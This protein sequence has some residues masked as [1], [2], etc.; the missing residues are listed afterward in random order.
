M[1]FPGR[2]AIQQRVLTPYR[3]AF[4]DAL[5]A[6]CDGGLD[7]IAGL[8][9]S[10]ESIATASELKTGRLFPVRN[11]HLFRGPLYLCWQLGLVRRLAG[12]S[13]DVL[14][15]EANPRTLST[16]AAVRWMKDRRRLVMGWGLGSPPI[17]GPLKGLRRRRRISFLKQFDGLITYSSRGAEEYASLGYP[18]ERISVA[19]NAAA[20]KPAAPPTPRS[21][22]FTGR[23]TILF[24]GRLQG[25][26]QVDALIRACASLD[27]KIQPRLVI[28]GDG[29]ESSALQD[30]ARQAYPAAEFPGARHGA[31]LEPFFTA[32]DLFVL[33]GTGGLAVQEAMAHGL[34]VVMGVGDGTTDDLVR[35]ANG[36]QCPHPQ[37]LPEVLANALADASRLRRMG[38]E[39]RRIVEEEINL[40][41]M[42]AVFISAINELT[43]LQQK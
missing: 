28:V 36:W 35:P 32:A 25:R 39:S 24:V 23:P 10:E 34:P 27:E 38:V 1:K 17:Q 11:F 26:K 30:L 3:A 19:P 22:Y 8:P 2:L 29:P 4:F 43:S 9:R 40:E 18:R 12:C 5:A 37:D 33:P 7:V 6:A 14:I 21:E 20:F 41:R 13:P 31:D 16:P 15:V 42:V